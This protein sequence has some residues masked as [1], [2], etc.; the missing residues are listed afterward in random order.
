M[1]V[2]SVLAGWTEAGKSAVMDQLGHVTLSP[3]PLGGNDL[4]SLGYV[5][6][7]ALGA[8]LAR[9]EQAWIESGFVLDREALL[10]QVDR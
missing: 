6:G 7:P 1:E 2:A 10:K 9:L 5:P 8:E 3:F 4:I